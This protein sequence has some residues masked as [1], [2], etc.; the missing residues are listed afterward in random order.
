MSEKYSSI[1]TVWKRNPDTNVIRF[2]DHRIRE[3]PFIRVWSVREKID[4]MNIRVMLDNRGRFEI[5]GRTDKAQIPQDLVATIT[6]MFSDDI[7]ARLVTVPVI[8]EEACEPFFGITFY[9]E[10][11]GP[12][13]Q[14]IGGQ[15]R[16]TKSFRVF[17][18]KFHTEGSSWWLP[19]MELD[20]YCTGLGLKTAPKLNSITG[21]MIPATLDQMDAVT[22]FGESIV[23]REDGPDNQP[24]AVLMEGIV[25]KTPVPMFDTYGNRIMW[26]LCYREWGKK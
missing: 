2:G 3:V 1:E 26:K 7:R 10:G 16:P 8:G 9:G 25:A 5:G 21:G 13:I 17:D 4:G 14:K 18:V 11:Y 20:E 12:G 24:T 23:A 19:D 6:D 22:G 15:Y